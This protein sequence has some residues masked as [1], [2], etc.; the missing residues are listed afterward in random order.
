[1]AADITPV[2]GFRPKATQTNSLAPGLL[3]TLTNDNTNKR[4]DVKVQHEDVTPSPS[5]FTVASVAT[6][7]GNAI[8]TKSNGFANVRVGDTVSGT[9]I[10]SSAVVVS[11]QSNSQVTL[12]VNS[13]ATGS[14]TVTFTPPVF[15]ANLFIVRHTVTMQGFS[16]QLNVKV[17]ASNGT[18]NVDSDADGADNSTVADYG[19]PLLDQTVPLNLDT[20]LTNVRVARG[21]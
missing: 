21:S 10:G 18:V 17:Y 5:S 20:W 19:D 2:A 6:T 4:F 13:T 15:D 11:K 9:G 7:S 16:L 12:S 1:M 14:V 8:I 3:V